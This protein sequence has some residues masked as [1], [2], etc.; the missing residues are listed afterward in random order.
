MEKELVEKAVANFRVPPTMY[1]CAQTV[2]S[3]TEDENIISDMKSCGGGRAPDGLCGALYAAI[4]I[5]PPEKR[6]EVR[7]EFEKRLG[8]QTCTELKQDLKVPCPVC[9]RVAAEVAKYVKGGISSAVK[10]A[11]KVVKVLILFASTFLS[12]LS[13]G[14]VEKDHLKLYASFDNTFNPEI[15]L[16]GF[17]T[18]TYGDLS[19]NKEEGRFSNA[20]SFRKGG[21]P[22]NLMFKPGNGFGTN[23]WTIAMW[24]NMDE[25]YNYRYRDR[26]YA[27]GL[28][29]VNGANYKKGGI[30]L[31]FSCW[32]EFFLR[33]S[34]FKDAK[35]AATI[36]SSKAIP[37][38]EWTHV[39]LV[40]RKDGTHDI[41]LNGNVASYLRKSSRKECTPVEMIHIGACYGADKL[42]GCVDEL[43]VFNKSL[44]SDE[45]S[46][47]MMSLPLRK[48][49]DI[50]AYIPCDGNVDGRGVASL[51]AVDLIFDEGAS[52]EGVKITRHGYD[53][54]TIM[55]LGG[56]E[57]GH[58]KTSLFFYFKPDWKKDEPKDVRHGLLATGG[59]DFYYTLEKN[60]EGIVFTVFSNGKSAK[61]VL[62]D[63]NW[64]KN[65]FRK[66]AAGYDY[67]SKKMYVALDDVKSEAEFNLPRPNA[68]T[69]TRLFVGEV[70]ESDYYSKTQAEGMLDEILVVKEFLSPLDIEEVLKTEIAKKVKKSVVTIENTPPTKK[71]V[72]LWN[73]DG[74]QR[75]NTLTREIITLNALWRFQLTDEKRLFDTK[76]W[77]YLAVPG[78]YAG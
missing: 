44:S 60:L 38:R 58:E 73:L 61:A 23:G 66:V 7:K 41:Y 9:V 52:Y 20:F 4:M 28:F 21:K 12:I 43:K 17:R 10:E 30:E 2:A 1:N 76:D 49:A 67:S 36:V 46:E 54:R 74:A 15:S 48:T 35:E 71:E 72:E 63:V 6:A 62:K 29:S 75:R 57:T 47:I 37:R 56:I 68:V 64:D 18:S 70:R 34:P 69:K 31:H 42:D 53:R 13:F 14:G 24:I 5:S 40:F 3:V 45:V 33:A 55:T 50:A 77:I 78:R 39:A 11:S 8:A 19:S 27:R 16:D 65:G 51:S 25:A 59:K 26:S 22:F 32:S